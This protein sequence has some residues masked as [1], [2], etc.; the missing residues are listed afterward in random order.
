MNAKDMIINFINDVFII[1]L[2]GFFIIYFVAG[3][4][5]EAFSKFMKAL[6]PLVIF[7]IIFLI[8]LRMDRA[9]LRKRKKVI[10]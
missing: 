8:K 4:H 10:F 2:I 6:L 7:G 3:D 9:H 1:S 5:F